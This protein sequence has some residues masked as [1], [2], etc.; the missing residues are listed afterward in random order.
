MSFFAQISEVVL[1]YREGNDEEILSRV[2]EL[3]EYERKLKLKD[4]MVRIIEKLDE[5][6]ELIEEINED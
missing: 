1:G 3:V 6:V 5:F 4:N 2:Q